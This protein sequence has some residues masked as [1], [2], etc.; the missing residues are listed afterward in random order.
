MKLAI[1]NLTGGRLSGGYK[2]Y[3]EAML[4]RFA[5]SREIA[6]ILCASPAAFFSGGW[7]PQDPKISHARCAP[8][9]PLKHGPGPELDKALNAF[10]P[11]VVF[12]PV[13]RY[14]RYEGAPLVTMVQ[15]LAPISGV[16]VACG[17][18][19]AFK[20]RVQAYETGLAVRKAAAV[21]TATGFAKNA[22]L[23]RFHVPPGKVTVAPFGSSAR[24][25]ITK[26]PAAFASGGG[27][28][29]LTVGSFEVYRGLEDLIAVLPRLQRGRPGLRLVVAGSGRP[30]AA[31]YREMLLRLAA[32]NGAQDAIVWAGQLEDPELSWCYS[33]CAA[34]VTTSRL[35]SFGFPA[36]EALAHGCG[37]VSA[38]SPCLPEILGD[39][40]AY[41]KAGDLAGLTAALEGVLMRGDKERRAASQAAEARATSFSWDR[42]AEQT[43][44]VFR[45]ALDGRA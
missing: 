35:E 45:R 2:R 25:C 41:Y 20:C 24:P 26:A 13:E 40:A 5:H 18:L 44:A 15:N 23:A 22:V 12:I 11:D 32:R 43:L 9:T 3:L 31:T 33:R 7:L 6:A 37:V 27:D 21:I 38:D 1:V 30:A 8:F 4:P 10:D 36:L 39:C 29:I 34:F 16:Q 14:L 17:L 19:D 28:F 42:T